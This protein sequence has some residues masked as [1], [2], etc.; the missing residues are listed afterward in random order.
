MKR[1]RGYFREQRK[2]A[3]TRKKAISNKVY[4][5]DWYRD[6][7]GKYDKGKIHCG[8]GI[9]KYCKKYNIPTVR[10][11]REDSKFKSD[12]EDYEKM[13]E[14]TDYDRQMQFENIKI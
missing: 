2:R 13:Y 10:R 5:F 7:D 6:A 1:S 9:C 8:C 12:L 3:I 4:G 14:Y 11:M